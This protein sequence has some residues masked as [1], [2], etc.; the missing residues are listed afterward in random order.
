MADITFKGN[1][2]TT[3]GALPA[4]GAAAPAFTL[5]GADLSEKTLAD[6]AGKKE[7]MAG[8]DRE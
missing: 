4:V 3:N 6:F 8:E 2:I 5:V 7:K 1:A